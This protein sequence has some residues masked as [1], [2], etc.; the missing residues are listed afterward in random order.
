MF[1]RFNLYSF[2]LRLVTY[3]TPAFA[4]LLAGNICSYVF[5]VCQRAIPGFNLYTTQYL[6]LLLITMLVWL[7]SAEQHNLTSVTEL[8]EEN[9]GVRRAI[10]A[11]ITTYGTVLGVLF[12]GRMLSFS[13]LFLIML[14][15][16]IMVLTLLSRA[17]LRVLIEAT[18][19]Y[20]PGTN[21]LIIG[22]DTFACRAAVRLAKGAISA[23]KIAGF[24]RL[25]GQNP[26]VRRARMYEAEDLDLL[27][28]TGSID[29]IVVALA[30]DK[31]GM[32]QEI[33]PVL[34]R[35]SV[36]IRAAVE[37]GDGIQIREK[38]LNLGPLQILSLT[39]T[40]AESVPYLVIKRCFDIAFSG[41]VLIVGSPLLIL[42]ALGVKLTSPGPVFFRQKRVGLNGKL[43]TMLKFRTMRVSPVSE[44]DTIWTKSA[45]PRRTVFGTFLRKTS[46]DELPQFLNVLRGDMSVVGPRPERPHFVR[47]F[48]SEC[49]KY[50]HRH[51][52]KVGITGWAQVHGLRGDTSIAKRV[53]YD[54]YYL[55]NW[56]FA[57]DLRIILMTPLVALFNRNAY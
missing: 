45:D 13:R 37:L 40:P 38:M 33:M 42:L 50:S 32:L 49:D 51:R 7:V 34:E 57:M 31:L 53:Q 11:C 27:A 8:L 19:P 52:L 54:L 24:V 16:A 21:F 1:E 47:K 25:P 44:S 9:T 46:L 18:R 48:Q 39:T 26:G 35:F 30:L 56:T 15:A 12:F 55:S 4:F 20:R 22:A 41:A 17:G 3:A 43:F 2:Y 29:E 36:P 14:P 5:K 6:L 28:N 10:S 23:A